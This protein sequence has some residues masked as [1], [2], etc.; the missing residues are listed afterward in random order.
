MRPDSSA[1]IEIRPGE[2]FAEI[3]A[4][5]SLQ[6]EV[7]QY[8]E[9]EVVPRRMFVVGRAIGGHLFCAWAGDQ[10]AGYAFAIPGVRE[11]HPYLHSHMVAV[12]EKF[13]NRGVGYHLKLAQRDDAMARGIE[14]IEWTFDPTQVRNAHFNLNKLGAIA[15]RYSPDFYG[16]SASAIHR[17]LP[18]DRLH[19]EWWVKSPRVASILHNGNAAP[20]VI[21][22]TVT[23]TNSSPAI[24]AGGNDTLRMPENPALGSLLH[25]RRQL[26]EAFSQG[27]CAVQFRADAVQPAYLL[28]DVKSLAGIGFSP[29]GIE[30]AVR[31]G[32]G[33]A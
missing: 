32:D 9:L 3:D 22:R 7:W 10:L 11:G 28:A 26:T 18:T 4:C 15:R 30:T 33:K 19:A 27:M 6:R 5:V 17:G 31:R 13:Q 12:A 20:P 25:L 16:P 8:P 23:V 24:S 29:G 2:T 1:A 14:L 21:Q